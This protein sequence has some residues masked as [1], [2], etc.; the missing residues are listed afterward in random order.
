MEI[1]QLKITADY[2]HPKMERILLIKSTSS[3]YRLH[4]TI[5][6]LFGFADYHLFEFFTK[7]GASTI[8]DGQGGFGGSRKAKDVKLSS[9][10]EN[11]NKIQYTYDFGDSWTFAITLQ[12]RIPYDDAIVYP[13]CVK[14]TGGILLE[15][16]GGAGCYNEISETCRE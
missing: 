8:S 4:R 15:D 5:Q 11:N 7:R 12:K 9:E 14:A 10:F 13:F 6:M 16:C 3:F 1:Y 2:I